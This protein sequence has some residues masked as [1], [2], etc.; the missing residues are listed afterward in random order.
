MTDAR[1]EVAPGVTRGFFLDEAEAE[2]VW[3]QIVIPKDDPVNGCWRW[4]GKTNSQMGDGVV[5]LRGRMWTVAQVVWQD[6][7]HGVFVTRA[8][9]KR[10][11]PNA[12]CPNPAHRQKRVTTSPVTAYTAPER[13][14]EAASAPNPTDVLLAK[15]A[16]DTPIVLPAGVLVPDPD[17]PGYAHTVAPG[18]RVIAAPPAHAAPYGTDPRQPRTLMDPARLA[19]LDKPGIHV[20]LIDNSRDVSIYYAPDVECQGHGADWR[21]ALDSS[22]KKYEEKAA[23]RRAR[24]GYQQKVSAVSSATREDA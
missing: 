14:V 19:L 21:A 13:P 5:Y 10:T 23:R 16:D 24:D 15:M 11:C 22:R 2:K 12:W 9:L 3:G 7:G 20:L 4:T 17:A 1:I 18:E 8:R 6:T